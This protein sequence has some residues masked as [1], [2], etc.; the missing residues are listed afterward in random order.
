MFTSAGNKKVKLGAVAFADPKFSKA[1]GAFDI[2]IKVT[3]AANEADSDWA[4]L[5]MSSDYGTGN[6][7]NRTQ[8][9]ITMETLRKL[10]FEGDDLT[11]LEDQLSGKDAIVHVKEAKGKEG[12]RSFFNVKYFVTGGADPEA[13]DKDEMKRRL[14]ILT[15]KAPTTVGGAAATAAASAATPAA[16]TSAPVNPPRIATGN[17]PFARKQQ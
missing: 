15:G 4:R 8:T 13:I 7:S 17:N 6:F 10:G 12:D 1:T 5:E 16:A 3:D 14:A 9:E 11:T 2:C